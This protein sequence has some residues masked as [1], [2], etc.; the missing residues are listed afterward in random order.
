MW[1][2]VQ[3]LPESLVRQPPCSTCCD[4]MSGRHPGIADQGL[5]VNT[6]DGAMV[7]RR[8]GDQLRCIVAGSIE[9]RRRRLE[10][11]YLSWEMM[12]LLLIEGDVAGCSVFGRLPHLS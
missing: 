10:E 8:G 9:K 6:V 2:D 1:T 5:V 4:T 12:L 3:T 7:P 11:A